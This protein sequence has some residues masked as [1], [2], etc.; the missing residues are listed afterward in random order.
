MPLLASRC[1]V[2]IKAEAV[3]GTAEALAAANVIMCT[4][5]PTWDPNVEIIPRNILS[6]SA[7][8]RGV[9]TGT[10]MAKISF[11]MFQRGTTGAIADPA[12]LPDWTVPVRSSGMTATVSGGGGSEIMTV[13]PSTL[14]AA[15]QI[16]CSV[17]IYKDGK[18]YM[19]H[20]AQGN[21][22]K[23]YTVG[24]PI[25]LEFEFTGIFNTPTDVALLVPTYPA[26]IE[27]PFLGAALTIL[28]FATPKIKTLT[29]DLG[30][31]V[32]ISPYPN[33]ATGLFYAVITDRDPKGTIDVEEELVS[34][35]N[36]H[37]EFLAGTTGSIATGAFPS[38]GSQYNKI[39]DTYPKVQ[40]TKS[41]HADRDGIVTTPLDFIP[42]G[43]ADAGNDEISWV[44]Q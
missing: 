12:N 31:K 30:N 32:S 38:T 25:L 34:V 39:N 20:G 18:Q 9:V 21:V 5:A 22:K 24:S 3:K 28:G 19:I 36:W 43:N 14:A 42:R 35:K 40:Y 15:T 2:A 29:I 16:P 10:R 13:L 41:G 7:S 1:Q 4:E 8:S 11:K 26:V 27:P 6:A 37:A 23:T 33:T 17:A 44:Q